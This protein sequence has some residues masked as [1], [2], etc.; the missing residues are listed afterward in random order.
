MSLVMTGLGLDQFPN[1]VV[2]KTPTISSLFLG[3]I[4]AMKLS[5]LTS[6]VVTLTIAT[7][8]YTI[9]VLAKIG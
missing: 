3:V 5:L 4:Y 7:L 2:V 8:H 9:L 6:A 1:I